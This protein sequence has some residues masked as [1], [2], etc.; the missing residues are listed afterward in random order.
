MIVEGDNEI[1]KG[2]LRTLEGS[3]MGGRVV[4][5]SIMS[6]QSSF[7]FSSEMPSLVSRPALDSNKSFGMSSLN[8][9]DKDK[10]E[11]LLK[12]TREWMKVIG[13]FEQPKFIYN[14]TQKHF[15]KYG[16]VYL[17]SS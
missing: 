17:L 5:G 15:E 14:V 16:F 10:E 4:Q 11:D 9:E 3:M 12:D 1:L 6:R 7:N 2:I 13:A 8:V